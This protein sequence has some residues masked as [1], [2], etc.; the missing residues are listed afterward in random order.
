M[1]RYGAEILNWRKDE[2]T[3]I[4][5]RARKLIKTNKAFNP[6]SDVSWLYAKRKQGGRGLIGIEMCVKGEENNLARYIE[7]TTEKMLQMVRIHGHL[8]TEECKD[9]KSLGKKVRR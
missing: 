9:P 6:K 4:D 7:N 2:I 1:L 8:N 3:E 5:R